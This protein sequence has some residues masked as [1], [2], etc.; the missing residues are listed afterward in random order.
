MGLPENKI[1]WLIITLRIKMPKLW[2]QD[3]FTHI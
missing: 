2:V 1:A 3:I